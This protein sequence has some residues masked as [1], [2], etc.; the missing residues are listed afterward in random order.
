MD[1][2]REVHASI[3]RL[4][5]IAPVVVR[6][7]LGYV[8]AAHGWQ[9]LDGGRD[10]IS[11]LGGFL[12]TKNVPLPDLVAWT[13]TFL[14]FG[15]GILLIVGL[16]TRLSALLIAIELTLAALVVTRS[17]GLIGARDVGV[18]YERDLVYIAA[19]AAVFLIGPG[20]PSL[21]HVLGLERRRAGSD[22]Q[23]TGSSR[24][25]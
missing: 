7:V 9:K 11:G 12:G 16:A 10:L 15:A 22:L 21:D 23:P 14:E 3:S 25:I 17:N 8:M 13:V 18:G 4:G 19:A 20:R 2:V 6:V 1:R 24:L 5:D